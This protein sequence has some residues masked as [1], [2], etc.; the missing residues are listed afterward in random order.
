VTGWIPRGGEACRWS[1]CGSPAIV[2]KLSGVSVLTALV[3]V[4]L[5]LL[6]RRTGQ[7]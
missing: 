7:R 3:V 5:V 2:V 1:R 4:L 6:L